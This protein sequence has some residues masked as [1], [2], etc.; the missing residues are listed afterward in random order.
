MCST[1]PFMLSSSPQLF[2]KILTALVTY[3]TWE[4]QN[5]YFF[6]VGWY[7]KSQSESWG[8]N[9]VQTTLHMLQIHGFLVDFGKSQ[10]DNTSLENV[11]LRLHK[12][13]ISLWIPT[14]LSVS[15]FPEKNTGRIFILMEARLMSLYKSDNEY[16]ILDRHVNC[17][18]HNKCNNL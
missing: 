8:Q 15:S 9:D 5:T 18:T 14:F 10:R 4:P 17:H 13:I 12:K 3:G 16:T 1:Q 6:L 11:L 2:M 7:S